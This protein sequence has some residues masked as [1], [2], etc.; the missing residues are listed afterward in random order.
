M[1]ATTILRQYN[2][3]G[4]T[5]S[6]VT[7]AFLQNTDVVSPATKATA[8]AIPV[9]G[10]GSNFSFEMWHKIEVTGG[11]YV[12]LDTF[13]HHIGAAVGNG[14]LLETSAQSGTPSNETYTT[15]INTNSAKADTTMPTTDPAVETIVGSLTSDTE[16]T[17]HV[18]MQLE[19]PSTAT[20]GFD[21]TLTYV[22]SETT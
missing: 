1:A 15:P 7:T 12:S 13:R 21:G 5:E 22:W 8:T 14:L 19:V 10:A 16:T 17:G 11:T 6:A 4:E 3:A 20:G 9:P 18:V 2:G